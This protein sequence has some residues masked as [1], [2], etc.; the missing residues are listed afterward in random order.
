MMNEMLKDMENLTDVE[1][2]YLRGDLLRPQFGQWDALDPVAH[3]ILDLAESQSEISDLFADEGEHGRS[4]DGEFR[5]ALAKR[6]AA[7]R[8]LL[9]AL[10]Q[11]NRWP[12][13][14]LGQ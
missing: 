14:E 3:A 2:F 8:K 10:R 7:G 12:D 9:E 4:R 6:D 11:R 5:A 13:P 1:L